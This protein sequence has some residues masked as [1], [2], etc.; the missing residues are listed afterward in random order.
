VPPIQ[1]ASSLLRE[2]RRRAGITQSQLAQRAGTTQSVVSAYESGRR[3]PSL[4]ILLGFIAATGHSLEG[5]LV[6]VNSARTAPLA[7]ALG[8][9]VRRHRREI[10]RIAERHGARD[11]RIFGSVA[12]GTER[13]DSDID[14]LVELPTGT[15]LFALGGL[16]RELED[17]LQAR[18]DVVPA[19]G[20]KPEVRARID[21]ELVSL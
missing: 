11:V 18:V 3:Q 16:R 19:D 10:A 9:R 1:C 2:A 6:T 13:P 15:G 7:G 5:A 17:L 12:R 8:R 20:L 4:P 14:L 21:R